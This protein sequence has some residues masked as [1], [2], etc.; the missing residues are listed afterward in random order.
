MP[1]ID[2]GTRVQDD[3]LNGQEGGLDPMIEVLNPH[4]HEFSGH[5][6]R[7][8]SILYYK[9]PCTIT[10]YFSKTANEEI[11]FPPWQELKNTVKEKLGIKLNISNWIQVISQNIGLV[12]TIILFGYALYLNIYNSTNDKQKDKLETNDYLSGWFSVL[13]SF[14]GTLLSLSAFLALISLIQSKHAEHQTL[15]SIHQ[16]YILKKRQFIYRYKKMVLSFKLAEY[17]ARINQKAKLPELF[18]DISSTLILLNHFVFK[19][20]LNTETILGTCRDI[21][22]D[23]TLGR[24]KDNLIQL[25]LYPE[26]FFKKTEDDNTPP[27]ILTRILESDY[28]FIH[29]ELL[30]ELNQQYKDFYNHLAE[31]EKPQYKSDFFQELLDTRKTQYA[32]ISVISELAYQQRLHCTEKLFI[33]MSIESDPITPELQAALNIYRKPHIPKDTGD[34]LTLSETVFAKMIL[35]RF[36]DPQSPYHCNILNNQPIQPA[37]PT[38]NNNSDIPP[39]PALVPPIHASEVAFVHQATIS[40]P[41]PDTSALNH[42][43][44][45][46]ENGSCLV[47]LPMPD[48]PDRSRDILAP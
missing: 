13:G 34:L 17:I 42:T 26:N 33:R 7:Q 36:I 21:N 37:A 31:N 15:M 39:P 38:S 9:K 4:V 45:E 14:R 35:E 29:M 18:D 19:H 1:R 6:I 28:S 2:I 10:E 11:L 48:R 3:R 41:E 40:V 47:Y 12:I 24:L 44:I 8:L 46:T 25:L 32:L 30:Q 23:S 43:V 5:H 20:T 16:E 27:K 22:N